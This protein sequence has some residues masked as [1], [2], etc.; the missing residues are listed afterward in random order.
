MNKQKRERKKR[1]LR[2]QAWSCECEND[3]LELPKVTKFAY[4]LFVLSLLA[5]RNY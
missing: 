3:L 2:D 5:F 4:I 1:Y